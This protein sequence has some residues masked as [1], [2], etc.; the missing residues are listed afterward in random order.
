MAFRIKP[1]GDK[2]E[3]TNKP[4]IVGE[5]R[6]SQSVTTYGPGSLVDFPRMSAIIDG[7]DN[8]ENTLG[9]Y[10]FEQMKIHERNLERILGKKFFVQPQMI[11]DKKFLNGISAKRFPEYCYC[12]ECG[13]LDK[14]Y[15][16][17]LKNINTT[18][19]NRESICGICYQ[20]KKR[21]IKLKNLQIN[22]L[23]IDMR[24]SKP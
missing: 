22:F 1:K 14:Y 2:E 19:Y 7:I 18:V 13:A 11:D 16:I 6:K 4:K 21:K 3:Q 17:E 5:I 9:K 10:N 12:P 15:R 24:F 8:W 20:S 23:K